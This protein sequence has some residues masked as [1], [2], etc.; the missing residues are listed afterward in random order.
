[1][2]IRVW[3]LCCLCFFFIPL[4]FDM[5]RAWKTTIYSE[6]WMFNLY[7]SLLFEHVCCYFPCQYIVRNFLS[8]WGRGWSKYLWNGNLFPFYQFSYLTI[9]SSRLFRPPGTQHTFT[10]IRSFLNHQVFWHC[11]VVS[12]IFVVPNHIDHRIDARR[13]RQ[14][15]LTAKVI[16]K[17]IKHLLQQLV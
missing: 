2:K 9:Y 14:L 10:S 8:V 6:V 17:K 1:M 4:V 15:I 12:F 5:Q 3:I 16:K 11:F 7:I 13:S